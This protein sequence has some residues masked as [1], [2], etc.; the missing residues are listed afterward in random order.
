MKLNDL[1]EALAGEI[2]LAGPGLEQD[3]AA[4]A[5]LAVED[6]A[7]METLDRYSGQV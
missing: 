2:E 3:L 7:F 6:P 4:L 1:I 5:S